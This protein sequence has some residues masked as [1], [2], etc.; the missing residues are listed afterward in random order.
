VTPRF[1]VAAA[2]ALA[3]GAGGARDLRVASF[4]IRYGTAED[5]PNRWELRRDLVVAAIERIAPDVIGMQ[6]VLAF[7]AA[8]LRER[9][10]GYEYYGVGRDDGKAGGEQ[11]GILWRAARF[12]GLGRGTLWLSETPDVPGSRSWDSALPRV[13][14]WVRLRDRAAGGRT[15]VFACTHFDHRGATARLESARLLDRRLAEIAGPEPVVL[16]GDFNCDEESAPYAA[17]ARFA[18]TYRAAHSEPG[19][20]EGTFHEFR[21]GPAP[22]R[23]RIDWIRV[24]RR[25]QTKEAAVDSRP[26]DGRPPSDHHPIYA[27]LGW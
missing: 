13:A 23:D 2:L 4:N 20:G 9:L 11:C 22:S 19:L 18:D 10:P 6:E 26:V 16:A 25:F 24:S 14:S 8:F 21:G 17:L 1:L 12:D 3:V 15:F 5:G 27:T 7:Q